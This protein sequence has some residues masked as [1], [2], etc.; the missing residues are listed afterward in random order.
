[1]NSLGNFTVPNFESNEFGSI[2]PEI[3]ITLTSLIP[4]IPY[5]DNYHAQNRLHFP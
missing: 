4:S 1:M 5:L 3:L 2:L